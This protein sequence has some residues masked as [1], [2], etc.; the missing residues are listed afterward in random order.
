MTA[1][2]ANGPSIIANTSYGHLDFVLFVNKT[3]LLLDSDALPINGLLGNILENGSA[4]IGNLTELAYPQFDQEIH[5]FGQSCE[6]LI[7]IL[8]FILKFLLKTSS[9]AIILTNKSQV[10]SF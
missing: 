7:F 9:A 8:L 5:N 3:K 6:S 1:I 2:F 4:T 10:K